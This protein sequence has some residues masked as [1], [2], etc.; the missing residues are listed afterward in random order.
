M[1]SNILTQGSNVT[2]TNCL[3]GNS[4]N[5]SAIISIGG[6]V[7]FEHCTFANYSSSFRNTPA[8]LFKDYYQTIDD[9]IIFRPFNEALLPIVFLMEMLI[10]ILLVTP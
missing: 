8:F 4:N 10:Q 9:E 1:Y 2:A 3:F 6:S 7:N 5:Y